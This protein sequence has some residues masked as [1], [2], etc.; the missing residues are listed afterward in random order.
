MAHARLRRYNFIIILEKLK[1][2]NYAKAI[3]KFF[4]VDGVTKKRS[5]FCERASQ[6]ANL[7][8]PANITKET[9]QELA[10]LNELD[11]R[12]YNNLSDC[13]NEYNFGHLQFSARVKRGRNKFFSKMMHGIYWFC[14]YIAHPKHNIFAQ[15]YVRK[16]L[17]HK[18]NTQL[19]IHQ[20]S[21][22][23]KA[24]LLTKPWCNLHDALPCALRQQPAGIHQP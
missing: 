2:K 1:D 14:H 4:G 15:Y 20:K 19:R 24:V 3:E 21:I 13:G 23:I 10:N 5:A 8:H 18:C 7:L 16:L 22:R 9:R 12:L 6:R 17:L 11:L